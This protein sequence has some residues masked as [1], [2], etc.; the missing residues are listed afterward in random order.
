M[1]TPLLL[2][3]VT[4]VGEGGVWVEVCDAGAPMWA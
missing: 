2:D 3:I 1:Y 4:V